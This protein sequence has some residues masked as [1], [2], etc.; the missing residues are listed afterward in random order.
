MGVALAQKVNG[1]LH[2]VAYAS[3]TLH[4]HERNYGVTELEGLGVVWAAK[5]FR[6]YLYGHHC[7]MYTD[8]AALKVLLSPPWL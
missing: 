8:Q 5:C 1:V 7:D 2:L 4:P 3:Q 6:P